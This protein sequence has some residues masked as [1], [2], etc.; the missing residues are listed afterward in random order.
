MRRNN[1]EEWTEYGLHS[2][3][4][5][6]ALEYGNCSQH[7]NHNRLALFLRED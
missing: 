4:Q 1:E 7:G 5:H 3:V 2:N 6:G